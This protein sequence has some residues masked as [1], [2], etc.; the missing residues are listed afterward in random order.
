MRPHAV[1]HA[2]NCTK[3]AECRIVPA[4]DTF[5]GTLSPAAWRRLRLA[6]QDAG[7][8]TEVRPPFDIFPP[9]S[10]E[11]IPETAP[12]PILRAPARAR[13]QRR[14]HGGAAGRKRWGE[15]A[16]GAKRLFAFPI[17]EVGPCT[18]IIYAYVC[19][20]FYRV[21][22]PTDSSQAQSGRS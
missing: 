20:Y 11:R 2:Y 9:P 1:S 10:R 19:G 12:S 22:V 21:N 17:R 5:C 4:M 6:C 13:G 18:R 14:G 8:G 16:G 15:V 3:T 7:H